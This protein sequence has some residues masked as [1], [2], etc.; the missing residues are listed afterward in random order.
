L[1]NVPKISD[2][3]WKVMKFF[4]ERSPQTAS[5]IINNLSI[6]TIW[7]PKT[8][9]TLLNR[10][11]KKCVLGFEKKGKIYYYFPL[12]SED[13][14]IKE[15]QKLIVNK[16]YNGTV[17]SLLKSFIEDVQLSDSDIRELTDLL[18][19]KGKKNGNNK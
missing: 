4:W 17:K 5:D 13:E 19:R 3:E 12:F 1:S 16:L 7:N 11:V 2:S 18:K 8:I 15:E 10:L 6:I 9:K 14:C